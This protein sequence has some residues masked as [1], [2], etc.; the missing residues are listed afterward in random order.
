MADGTIDVVFTSPGLAKANRDL[1]NTDKTIDKIEKS[2]KKLGR[3]AN[4]VNK[5]IIKDEKTKVKLLDKQIKQ[6]DRA[7]RRREAIRTRQDRADRRTQAG[8]RLFSGA[9][10]VGGAGG[11]ALG[12]IG[13]G[14]AVGGI[15]GILAA[16]AAVVGVGFQALSVASDR[17]SQALVQILNFK[18]AFKEAAQGFRDERGARGATLLTENKNAILQLNGLLGPLSQSIFDLQGSIGDKG[19]ISSFLSA[20]KSGVLDS[21]GLA[22]LIKLVREGNKLGFNAASIIDNLSA[23]DKTTLSQRIKQGTLAQAGFG[24]S[25]DVLN[26]I[27]ANRDVARTG[28]AGAAQRR[29]TLGGQQAGV[30]INAARLSGNAGNA[31]L[32]A[33]TRDPNA[34]A[35]LKVGNEQLAKLDEINESAKGQFVLMKNLKESLSF[36]GTRSEDQKAV[37]LI[38]TINQ[39]QVS[40]Q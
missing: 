17:A 7:T 3:T 14:I 21:V 9:S 31:A 19:I 15:L 13:E 18:N 5:K 16:G 39:A 36:L 26:N 10:K 35:Q 8:A 1:E 22:E 24:V 11:T 33:R 6:L 32:L 40:V 23:I 4:A 30:D 12:G 29:L 25:G 37:D 38:A 2:E 20:Q 34:A 27:R 28:L